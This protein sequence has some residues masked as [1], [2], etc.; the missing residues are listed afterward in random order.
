MTREDWRE[1]Y[2]FTADMVKA[3]ATLFAAAAFTSGIVAWAGI[4]TGAF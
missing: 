4:L 2:L 3:L 1:I